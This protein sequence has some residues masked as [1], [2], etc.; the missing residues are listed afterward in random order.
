MRRRTWLIAS[1]A[2][3]CVVAGFAAYLRPGPRP[4]KPLPVVAAVKVSPLRKV[5]VRRTLVTYGRVIAA[6][7]AIHTITEPFEVAVARVSVNLGQP[8]GQ[9]VPLMTLVPAASTQLALLRAQTTLHLARETLAETRARYKLH[10]ATRSQLLLA[11]RGYDDARLSLDLLRREGLRA[12]MQIRAPVRGVVS[13]IFTQEGAIVAAG[14]PLMAMI[15]R[16]HLEVRLGAESEDIGNLQPGTHVSLRAFA[17]GRVAVH[18]LVSVVSRVVNPVTHMVDV[19]VSLPRTNPY[20]LG[21][22]VEGRFV[23]TSSPVLVA[24][25]SAVLTVD[26]RRI[27]YTIL[28]GRAVQHVVRVGLRNR[29]VIEILAPHLHPGE[30][31]VVLG[32]YELKPGMRVKVT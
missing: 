12:H 21:E 10:L 27:I 29:R 7:S 25:R 3:V 26:H 30:P 32:N 22:Y 1:G 31:V 11:R 15:A 18:G 8:V 20:L 24:P 5:P 17:N 9:G 6:P 16:D 2:V 13:R 4:P 28:H 19:F 14:Q 23:T